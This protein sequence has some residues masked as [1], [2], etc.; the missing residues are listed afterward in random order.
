[1]N[2]WIYLLRP[3]RPAMVDD[4]T[5]A[6]QTVLGAHLA[7]LQ[8]LRDEGALIVAG[9]SVAGADTFGLVVLSI[10]DEREARAAM[11][12][13]PAV[14]RGIMTAELRPIRLSVVRD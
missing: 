6:E 9:P 14:A 2:G 7:H 12:A 10:A 4:P 13:D 1:L 8:R 11:E 3:V 5:E